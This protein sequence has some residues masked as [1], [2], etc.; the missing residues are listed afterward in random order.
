MS[1]PADDPHTR[2]SGRRPQ[3]V[4]TLGLGFARLF[5]AGSV[6]LSAGVPVVPAGGRVNAGRSSTAGV[7]SAGVSSGAG[8]PQPTTSIVNAIVSTVVTFERS[9]RDILA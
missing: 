8:P 1:T 7:A 2:P 3:F 4:M 6:T 9:G 5:S